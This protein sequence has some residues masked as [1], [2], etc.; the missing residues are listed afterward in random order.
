MTGRGTSPWVLAGRGMQGRDG[1]PGMAGA[2]PPEPEPLSGP[3]GSS[4]SPCALW[5][6]SAQ[7]A[8]AE[9]PA[10]ASQQHFPYI[11]GGLGI[12]L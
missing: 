10:P 4:C 6:A 11:F 8:P 2:D 7:P 9:L 12:Y 3:T 5:A 1:C